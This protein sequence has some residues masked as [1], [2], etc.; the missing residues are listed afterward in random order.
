LFVTFEKTVFKR[1]IKNIYGE[2]DSENDL[3]KLEILQEEEI[4][5]E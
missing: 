1:L 5:K 2:K 4:G 3:M